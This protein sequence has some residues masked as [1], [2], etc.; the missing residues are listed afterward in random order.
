VSGFGIREKQ[1][2]REKTGEA[3]KELRR[4]ERRGVQLQTECER[5]LRRETNT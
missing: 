2:V 3:A 1:R 5:V 4:E